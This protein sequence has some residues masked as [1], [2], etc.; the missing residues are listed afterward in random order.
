VPARSSSIL[1]RALYEVAHALESAE[2]SERRVL[3]VLDLLRTIVPSEHCALLHVQPGHEPRLVAAPSESPEE[4]AHVAQRLLNLFD[5]FAENPTRTP[6]P[7]PSSPGHLAVPLVGVDEVIGVLEVRG[8]A[9]AYSVEHLRAVSVV[10]AQ[11]A[12]HLV[13]LRARMVEADRA[14]ELKEARHAAEAANRAKDEFLALVSHE[15]KTPLNTTLTWAHT[16]GSEELEPAARAEAAAGIERAVRAQSKL[17]D[18]LLDLVGTASAALRLDVRAVEPARLIRATLEGL[19]LQAEA[20]AIRLETALDTSVTNLIVDPDRFEQIVSNLVANAIKF[21]PNGGC[22]EVHLERADDHARIRVIDRGARI[23][24]EVLPHVFESFRLER[25]AS[26]RTHGAFGVGLAIVKNLVER[27]GGRIRAES[28]TAASGTTFTVELP[29]A[30]Q[31][32]ALTGIRVVVVDDD[33][34]F[35]DAL[36]AVLERRG[37]E[38]M[39]VA[40]VAAALAA[41]DSWKPDVLLSELAMPRESGYDLIRHVVARYPTLPVAALTKFSSVAES[42]RAI[43]AGFQL[44]LVKPIEVEALVAA[45]VELAARSHEMRARAA[46]GR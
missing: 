16:L 5:L 22:V 34:D 45:I 46:A 44:H 23:A 4:P 29:L 1:G 6:E 10:A 21:T 41:L 3:R 24:P 43:A 32:R 25:G 31:A 9:D 8:A 38:V 7:Q 17:I 39:T 26:P 2:D 30:A 12:A 40:S 28:A 37:A 33:D 15:L 19:R 11:L 27:H 36:R 20:R 35:R 13:I 18:E 42:E 14:R